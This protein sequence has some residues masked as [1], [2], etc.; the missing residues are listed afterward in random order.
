[1]Y[2]SGDTYL[3]F[4]DSFFKLFPEFVKNIYIVSFFS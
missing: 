4:S 2:L 3:V 1:M